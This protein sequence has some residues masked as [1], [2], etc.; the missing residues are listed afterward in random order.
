ML[1][2]ISIIWWFHCNFFWTHSWFLLQSLLKKDWFFTC[3]YAASSLLSGLLS[4]YS[5]WRL[6]SSCG[7]LACHC[8]GSSCCRTWALGCAGFSSSDSQTLEHR[9]SSCATW[10]S[11]LY[12]TCSVPGSG[13]KPLS[14]TLASGFSTTEPPGKPLPSLKIFCWSILIYNVSFWC[15]SSVQSLSHIQLFATPWTASCQTSLSITNSRSLLKLMFIES[16]MPSNHLILCCPLLLPSIFSS[17]IVF[18]NES[19]LCIRWPKYWS[20]SI[21]PFN[22]YSGFISFRIDWFDISAVQGTLKS[23]L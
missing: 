7:A 1:R 6:L 2:F 10:A 21:R 13:I 19:V 11:L 12:S 9:L 5:E 20:F 18:S 8:S 17:I 16:V 14:S 4:A 22:E 23:L 15:I 3:G